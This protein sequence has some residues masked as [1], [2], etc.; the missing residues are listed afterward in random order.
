MRDVTKI[1]VWHKARVVVVDAYEL[2][3]RLPKREQYGLQAQIRRAAVSV[4]ANIA[5]GCARGSEGDLERHLRIAAGSAAELESL[6]LVAADLK[7]LDTP[8]EVSER[9]SEVR[10]MLNGFTRTVAASRNRR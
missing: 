5:E 4:V 9:I 7:L 10:K 1:A 6:L 8:K 3:A 2:S